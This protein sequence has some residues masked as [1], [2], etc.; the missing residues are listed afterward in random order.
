MTIEEKYNM[1]ESYAR[2]M[3]KTVKNLDTKGSE[4]CESFRE[5]LIDAYSCLVELLD[6]LEQK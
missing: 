4:S 6:E 2:G 5:G 1:V 3:L